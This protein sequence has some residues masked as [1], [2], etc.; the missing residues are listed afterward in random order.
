MVTQ[1]GKPE[2]AGRISTVRIQRM[3]AKGIYEIIKYDKVISLTGRHLP[4]TRL[5]HRLPHG[6]TRANPARFF[7]KENMNEKMLLEKLARYLPI[8]RKVENREK[9][10]GILCG[11]KIR[12]YEIVRV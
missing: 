8:M 10:L 9:T 3:E 7:V 2:I 11:G 6:Y 12:E 4:T 1:I 5:H